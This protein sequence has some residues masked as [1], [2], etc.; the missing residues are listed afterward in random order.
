[1]CVRGTGTLHTT[2]DARTCVIAPIAYCLEVRVVAI[3]VRLVGE[4]EEILRTLVA[5]DT[6]TK[7]S[8][9]MLA[10][11]ATRATVR[12]TLTGVRESLAL[13]TFAAALARGAAFAPSH[14]RARRM[15]TH[16]FSATGPSSAPRPL[17]PAIEP[18]ETGFLEVGKDVK[19][20]IYYEVCGN[21][22]G[23]PAIFLH[24]GPGSGCT[25]GNRQYFDPDVYKIVLFDQRGS[26]RSTPFACLEENT[27]WDL[28]SDIEVVRAKVGVDKWLVFG[29][30][31]GSTLALAY[32]ETHPARVT[33][34]VLRGI[35]TLRAEE[36]R[37]FYQEGANF[38]FPDAWEHYVAAIPA[39]ERHDFIAAYHRRLT[40]DNE[41]VKMA[42]AKAWSVWEGSTSKLYS[43]PDFIAKYEGDAFSLAFARIENVS[44][45]YLSL[46]LQWERAQAHPV[47]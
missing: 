13:T 4:R 40:S 2:L 42:A 9:L 30:S 22:D 39:E 14:T 21:K 34:L 24:G 5:P 12:R 11:A 44:S 46:S 23:K 31:W 37:F 29:G 17:Y 1:M 35:F 38:L 27:V 8:P 25:A 47:F 33:E 43:D 3:L 45:V 16:T 32:A 6:Q 19:H 26:G 36:L 41:E 20:S 10:R 28:V 7:T 18:Y 15:A